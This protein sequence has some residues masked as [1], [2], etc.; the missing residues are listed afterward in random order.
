ML[1][2]GRRTHILEYLKWT[3]KGSK[4]QTLYMHFNSLSLRLSSLSFNLN[5]TSL[6]LNQSSLSTQSLSYPLNNQKRYL[7]S[8]YFRGKSLFSIVLEGTFSLDAWLLRKEVV[9]LKAVITYSLDDL[10]RLVV[11][12]YGR[13][14]KLHKIGKTAS[15]HLT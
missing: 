8:F 12:H 14:L 15:Q 5:N 2:K 9:C 11:T 1:L 6:V 10:K 3:L 13:K 7:Y 4:W